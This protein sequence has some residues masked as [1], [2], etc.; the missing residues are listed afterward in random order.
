MREIIISDY[1]PFW[2][3]LF[4]EEKH[5]LHS[6]LDHFSPVIEHIGSTAVLNLGAKPVIDIMI[7]IDHEDDLDLLIVPIESLGYSYRKEHESEMPYRRFFRKDTD[8]IRSHHI[9]AVSRSHPFW[10]RHIA[11]RD[12][13]RN[14]LPDAI[15]YE[16]L[17]RSLAQQYRF[18]ADGYTEAKSAF[19]QSIIA[20]TE[21]ASSV[22]S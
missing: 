20:R 5:R 6:L 16:A 14:N 11:F 19:I 21:E 13:L 15:E 7:G 10:A 1:D 9:H 4:R 3:E 17:K 18:D 12:H 8:E 2:T 22:R